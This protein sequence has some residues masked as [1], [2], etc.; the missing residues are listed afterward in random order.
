MCVSPCIKNQV[1]QCILACM[2]TLF[3]VNADRPPY[4]RQRRGV[5]RRR[6]GRGGQG[7]GEG[8]P[9]GA[10]RDAAG[11][12]ACKGTAREAHGAQPGPPAPPCSVCCPLHVPI[13]YLSHPGPIFLDLSF[14]ATCWLHRRRAA[15]IRCC[16]AF[17]A[18]LGSGTKNRSFLTSR[19][20]TRQQLTL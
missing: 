12:A 17:V 6:E 13:F 20:Y 18:F 10:G 3:A 19:V 5:E 16:V 1:T 14:S 8:R 9:R 7:G 11:G 4:Q 2:Y 15:Y